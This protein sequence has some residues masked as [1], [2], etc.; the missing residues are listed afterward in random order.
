MCPPDT[1]APTR[2]PDP[3][4]YPVRT[5]CTSSRRPQ[6]AASHA[7][8]GS[9]RLPLNALG[10]EPR[11]ACKVPPASMKPSVRRGPATLGSHGQRSDASRLRG[12]GY[13]APCGTSRDSDASGGQGL[14]P[15]H[16]GLAS[17][18]RGCS[19]RTLGSSGMPGGRLAP[20]RAPNDGKPGPP[21]P[22]RSSGRALHLDPAAP[23]HPRRCCATGSRGP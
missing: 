15:M 3:S 17:G 6:A 22:G 16:P 13:G 2:S 18:G 20:R 11:P 10:A 5:F 1:R 14:R 23:A 12:P 7:R 19:P 21:G 4:R 8:P 9:R